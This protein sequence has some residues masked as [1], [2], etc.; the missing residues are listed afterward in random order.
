MSPLALMNDSP[1]RP[2]VASSDPRSSGPAYSVG[3]D[4]SKP[5][6]ECFA[7]SVSQASPIGK[8][9]LPSL[10]AAGPGTGQLLSE[11]SWPGYVEVLPNGETVADLISDF[12]LPSYDRTFDQYLGPSSSG[13]EKLQG[14]G[15]LM[16]SA[17]A[18]RGIKRT[19]QSSEG[20]ERKHF[21]SI[22][23]RQQRELHRDRER[24]RVAILTQGY[25]QL[26]SR[27]PWQ[28]LPGPRNKLSKLQ[29]LTLSTEY[30]KDLTNLLKQGGDRS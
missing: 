18:N 29:V 9:I 14:S 6:Q 4:A 28:Y 8:P 16:V 12:R 11:S 21:L 27:I 23:E 26:R 19:N 24:H 20:S 7:R 17:P 1:Y 2:T 25:E 15:I 3:W 13:R 22:E 5:G 30:I 10:K